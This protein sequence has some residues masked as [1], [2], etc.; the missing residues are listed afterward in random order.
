M[1]N[2]YFK[3]NEKIYCEECATHENLKSENDEYVAKAS[4]H[5]TIDSCSQCQKWVLVDN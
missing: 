3:I 1:K 4:I 2:S 5:S